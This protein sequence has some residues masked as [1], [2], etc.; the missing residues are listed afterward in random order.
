M[1]ARGGPR[2]LG[3]FD[4]DML[5]VGHLPEMSMIW[6]RGFGLIFGPVDHGCLSPFSKVQKQPKRVLSFKFLHNFKS[7]NFQIPH[8]GP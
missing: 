1:V 8:G 2:A 3:L 4:N 7:N 5:H 6:L